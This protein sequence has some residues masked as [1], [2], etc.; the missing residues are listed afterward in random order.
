M[1]TLAPRSAPHRWSTSDVEP[2]HALS[3]W[4]DTVFRS[5]L[6]IDSPARAHYRASL[7][8]ADFGPATLYLLA[9]DPHSVR[10]TR[11]LISQKQLPG[12]FL[13][14]L[15][16]GHLRFEQSGRETCIGVGDSLLL[17][18]SAPYQV[19][20]PV[21]TRS[22]FMHFQ[23]DWLQNWIPAPEKIV[24]QPFRGAAGWGA[25]LAALLA[26]L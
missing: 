6:E 5:L 20:C 19:E 15:R 17:N 24:A 9:G 22:I 8:V 7:Q 14:H 18:T 23:Q 10:R 13:V 25:A 12:Y 26:N 21:H 11:A 3:Y 16:A 4:N 1:L 2:R